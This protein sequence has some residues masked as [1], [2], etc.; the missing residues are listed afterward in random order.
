MKQYG[1]FQRE[2]GLS[3]SKSIEQVFLC[4]K[5]AVPRCLAKHRLHVDAGS[6]LFNQIMKGVPVLAPKHAAIVSR[7]VRD[8]SLAT[9]I[10]APSTEDEAEKEKTTKGCCRG[11]CGCGAASAGAGSARPA[12]GFGGSARWEPRSSSHGKPDPETE[13]V[14]AGLWNIRPLVPSWQ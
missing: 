2:R 1:H 14:K 11:S 9:M 4:W 5:G 12:S 7:E 10:G 6:S 8:K 3:N 13:V